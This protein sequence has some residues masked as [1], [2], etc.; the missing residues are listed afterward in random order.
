MGNIIG[1]QTFQSRDAPGYQPAKITLVAVA[2]CGVVV[3]TALRILYGIRNAR[4]DRT[5]DLAQSVSERWLARN[6]R[7][8]YVQEEGEE[9]ESERRFRY[10]Y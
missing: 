1:P 3:T 7:E 5:G 10:V 9:E 4:A 2:A 6:G 8:Q